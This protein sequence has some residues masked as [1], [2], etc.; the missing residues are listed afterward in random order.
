[1]SLI[2]KA[3]LKDD[4]D[5]WVIKVNTKI[6]VGSDLQSNDIVEVFNRDRGSS[7]YMRVRLDGR[8]KDDIARVNREM[9]HID[10]V[11]NNHQMEITK[12]DVAAYKS[13]AFETDIQISDFEG[14]NIAAHLFSIT[15]KETDGSASALKDLVVQVYEAIEKRDGTHVTGLGTGYLPLAPGSWG[16]LAVSV[17][18]LGVVCRVRRALTIN[19]TR[20]ISDHLNELASI[21]ALPLGEVLL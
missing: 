7:R 5:S 16:S 8:I 21:S 4:I 19:P 1:M 14:P 18:F 2:L 3:S 12:V 17:I 9:A 15:D 10:G 20:S 13:T 11:A 6:A